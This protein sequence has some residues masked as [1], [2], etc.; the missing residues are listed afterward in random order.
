MKIVNGYRLMEYA[1]KNQFILPAF[2]TTN[3]EMT[4]GISNGLAKA[5]LPGYIQVSSS[6]LKLSNP[7]MMVEITKNALKHIDIPIALHLD[8]GQS[9][10]DVKDCVDAGFTSI[11][12][13]A[14]HLSF[15]E[16]ITEVKKTVDYCHFYGIPVEA[17]LGALGGKE[18]DINNETGSTTDPE[19]VKEFVERS[20]CDLLAVSVGN[21]HGLDLQP[22]VNLQLLKNISDVSPVPLVM[23]GGS[24]IPFDTIRKAKKFNLLKINYGADLRKVFIE[25]F[26]KEYQKNQN[27]HDVIRLSMIAVSNVSNKANELVKVINGY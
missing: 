27:A 6:N 14:S 5:K 8:H 22:N 2:N 20:G 13:D 4:I 24:G 7:N 9:F 16:N 23:H 25:S 19:V 12:I 11:M 17:E 15:E 10:Q 1:K 18:E 21:V 3:L 26:G